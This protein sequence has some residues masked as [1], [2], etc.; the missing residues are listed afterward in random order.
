L[1]Y[2]EK[3]SRRFLRW[4]KRLHPNQLREIHQG[5]DRILRDPTI[6]KT[7]KGDLAGHFVYK[8][9]VVGQEFLIVYTVDDLK[10]EVTFEAAGS[11]E[12]FYRDLKR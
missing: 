7:K 5:L 11:H 9:S 6:G 1:N 12:N 3:F 2:S 8:F 10:L 4:Y